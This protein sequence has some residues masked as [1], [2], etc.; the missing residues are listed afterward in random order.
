MYGPEG[1]KA[2][3]LVCLNPAGEQGWANVE[4]TPEWVAMTESETCGRAVMVDGS[5]AARFV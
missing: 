2:G 5:G 4:D 3:H 1:P